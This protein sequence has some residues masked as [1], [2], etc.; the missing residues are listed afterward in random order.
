MQYHNKINTLNIKTAGLTIKS[1]D[2]DTFDKVHFEIPA[3][4]QKGGTVLS[5][6]GSSSLDLNKISMNF[7]SASQLGKSDNFTLIEELSSA[8]IVLFIFLGTSLSSYIIN[9]DFNFS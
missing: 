9:E 5:T 8:D 1:I 2:F 6:S 7:D 4:L 3:T